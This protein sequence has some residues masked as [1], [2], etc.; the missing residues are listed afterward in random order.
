VQWRELEWS[1]EFS[2]HVIEESRQVGLAWQAGRGP[3][4][5]AAARPKCLDLAHSNAPWLHFQ[6]TDKPNNTY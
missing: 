2:F 5:L 6:A 1:D 3:M 4:G